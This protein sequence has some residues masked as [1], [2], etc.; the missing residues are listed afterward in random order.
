MRK[1]RKKIKK[2][3]EK[4]KVNQQ[5]THDYAEEKKIGLPEMDLKKVMGCGG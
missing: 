5:Y 3:N 2:S 4:D 1:K